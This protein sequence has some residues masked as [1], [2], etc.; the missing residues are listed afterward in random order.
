MTEMIKKLCY[1]NNIICG[2]DLIKNLLELNFI[3]HLLDLIQ[4]FGWYCVIN[5]I[6][7]LCDCDG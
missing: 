5:P 2:F 6:K 4:R 3:Y 7:I 1:E